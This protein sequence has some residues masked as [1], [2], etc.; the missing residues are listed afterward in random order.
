MRKVKKIKLA[1][2][3]LPPRSRLNET[4]EITS[5]IKSSSD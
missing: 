1:E 2:D 4:A 5:S 3:P